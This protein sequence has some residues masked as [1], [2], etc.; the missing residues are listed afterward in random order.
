MQLSLFAGETGK[1]Q[2]LLQDVD[3]SECAISRFNT[4]KTRPSDAIEKLAERISQN[5]FELTRAVWAYRNGSNKLEVFAGGTRLEAA[6]CAGVKVAVVLHEGYSEKEISKLSD[7]DNENDEYHSP[8]LITDVWAE[9][10]RLNEEEN[11][12]QQE[13]ADAK[14]C[15]RTAVGRRIQYHHLPKAI[16]NYVCQGF[17]TEGHLLEIDRLCVDTHL[18]SSI[19]RPCGAPLLAGLIVQFT[20]CVTFVTVFACHP[21][22]R[23]ETPMRTARVLILDR[24]TPAPVGQPIK[25][26]RIERILLTTRFFLFP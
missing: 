13:I 7:Q 17:L 14:G 25:I 5:G 12:T 9:Y 22:P 6:K 11:W 18:S 1:K 2:T 20:L 4:R 16:K 24:A 21:R 23:G 19:P 8:V 26:A 10:V 15:E 3:P